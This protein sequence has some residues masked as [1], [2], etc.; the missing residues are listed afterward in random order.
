M[1]TKH[2]LEAKVNADDHIRILAY[3]ILLAACLG[4]SCRS[5]VR[6][7]A[8]K[9]KTTIELKAPEDD[10]TAANLDRPDARGQRLREASLAR[11][12][13]AGF[14]PSPALPTAAHRRSV[15]GAVRPTQEIAQRLL[16]LQALVAWVVFPAQDL[17]DEVVLGFVERNQLRAWLTPDELLILDTPRALAATEHGGSIGWRMENMWP[18][19]WA[20]GFEPEPDPSSGMV[21]AEIMRP[22]FREFL[23]RFEADTAPFL[24]KVKPRSL[25]EIAQLEDLFYCAHNAVRSAQLGSKDAVPANF[26]PVRDGGVVHERRLSLTWV[27]SPNTSWDETDLST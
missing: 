4:M 19:A 14:R 25:D 8:M 15:A 21:G 23:P 2:E 18:L 7:P 11:L 3:P 24:A 13:G 16:A 20:L 9:P 27:L 12:R 22:L 17:K 10:P 6:K 5:E 26:E 1:R